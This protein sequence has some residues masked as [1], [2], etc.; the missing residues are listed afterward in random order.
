ML[1]LELKQFPN[2][3]QS[4]IHQDLEDR[5]WIKVASISNAWLVTKIATHRNYAVRE[6]IVDLQNCKDLLGLSFPL[7]WAAQAAAEGLKEGQV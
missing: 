7:P 6:C 4:S 2:T 3:Q 5:G 1:T